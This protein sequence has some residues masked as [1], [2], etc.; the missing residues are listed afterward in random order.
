MPVRLFVGNL[1]YEVSEAELRSHFAPAGQ[2]YSVFIP[3]DRATGKPR[4]FA[5]IEFNEQREAEEAIRLF[6]QQS[7][8]GRPLAVN[9]AR[10]KEA[11]PA[12]PRPF[13]GGGGPPSAG[14]S[15]P[16][17]GPPRS[18]PPP[19]PFEDPSG[20]GDKSRRFGPNAKPKSSRQFKPPKF[21]GKKPLKERLSG[22]IYGVDDM[23]DNTEASANLDDFATSLEGD[24]AE[25]T[26]QS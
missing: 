26:G 1:P 5:F 6:H 17:T 19:A 9:E 18:G 21:E 20:R 3:I 11:R 7:F 24:E 13:T 12:G 23:E 10:P 22:R 16:R 4:G 2:L 14:P 8:K 15:F 25:D